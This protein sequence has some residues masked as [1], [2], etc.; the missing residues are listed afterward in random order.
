MPKPRSNAYI[1]P[2]SIV[3]SEVFTRYFTE[4][5]ASAYFVA[6]PKT[7]VIHIQKT[8]PG[9][10]RVMAVA[11]P[12]ILPVPLV[13][14]SAVAK[15]PN[16]LTSPSPPLS[17]VNDSLIPNRVNRWMKR[18]RNVRNKWVPNNKMR[19]GGPQMN[20]LITVTKSWNSC[21]C[22]P[23]FNIILRAIMCIGYLV[24]GVRHRIQLFAFGV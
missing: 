23:S 8:A 7:P 12:T 16:W 13:A 14:A 10:P 24:F 9:P 4:R 6:I 2:P 19:R 18:R 17:F 21:I 5:R 1:G 11:T 22:I 3:P 20:S 15:A